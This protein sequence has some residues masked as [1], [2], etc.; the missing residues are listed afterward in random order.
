MVYV[1]VG[2]TSEVPPGSMRLFNAGGRDIL[3]VNVNGKIYA[4]A[5]KCTHMGADLSQGKLQG[6]IVTCPRHGSTFDVTTGKALSGPK[7]G[8]LRL[9]TADAAVYEV[10][11]EDSEILVNVGD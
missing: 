7:I 9:K 2:K 4:M 11:V 10:R 8:P 3:V 6:I 1:K 5:G